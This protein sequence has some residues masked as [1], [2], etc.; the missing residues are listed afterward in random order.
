S[1]DALTNPYLRYWLAC[2]YSMA[3]EAERA[4]DHIE[5]VLSVPNARGSPHRIRLSPYFR[6]LHD[7]PRF[8]ALLARYDSV[9]F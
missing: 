5:F 8:Q 1:R 7:H 9:T 6:P 4:L 3:G 2:A